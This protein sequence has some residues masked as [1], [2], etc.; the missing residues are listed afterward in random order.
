MAQLEAGTG[1][2][3]VQIIVYENHVLSHISYRGWGVLRKGVDGTGQT[4]RVVG[5]GV[6]SDVDVDVDVAVVDMAG[7]QVDNSSDG[8]EQDARV[9]C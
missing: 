5:V 9:R 8:G 1:S 4:A 2:E 6:D 7:I 3:C